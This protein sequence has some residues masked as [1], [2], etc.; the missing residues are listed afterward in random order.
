MSKVTTEPCSTIEP[1]PFFDGAS[2]RC[3]ALR[4]LFGQF[5]AFGIAENSRAGVEDL[6]YRA[7]QRKENKRIKGSIALNFSKKNSKL[8]W[9]PN[10][11]RA[12]S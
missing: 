12:L 9:R 10:N 8:Q 4:V 5:S 7:F 6:A 3:S 2:R 1:G 11:T